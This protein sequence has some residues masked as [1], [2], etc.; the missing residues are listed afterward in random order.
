MKANVG[1]SAVPELH[2]AGQ[3]LYPSR[4]ASR[5]SF[6]F[7]TIIELGELSVADI[8]SSGDFGE[9]GGVASFGPAGSP[10][11]DRATQPA[12]PEDFL[13]LGQLKAGLVAKRKTVEKVVFVGLV[14]DVQ[15]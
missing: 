4:C 7:P 9:F 12:V 13:T 8:G 5:S 11:A 3:L 1:Q 14:Q 6:S 10:K 15:I 2:R